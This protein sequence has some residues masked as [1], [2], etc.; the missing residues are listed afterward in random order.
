MFWIAHSGRELAALIR[1]FPEDIPPRHVLAPTLLT[2]TRSAIFCGTHHHRPGSAGHHKNMK[3]SKKWQATRQVGSDNTTFEWR[4]LDEDYHLTCAY[5]ICAGPIANACE[6]R[7]FRTLG[8]Q[9]GLHVGRVVSKP[10]PSLRHAEQH[11]SVID[12]FD[13]LR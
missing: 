3:I 5:V 13:S 11:G 10:D 1:A 6:L 9:Q 12:W 4:I 8:V 7:E 2:Q